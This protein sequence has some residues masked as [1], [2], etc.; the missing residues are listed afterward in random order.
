MAEKVN[1]Q[2]TIKPAEEAGKMVVA[3]YL[4]LSDRAEVKY[5]ITLTSEEFVLIAEKALASIR[6]ILEIGR[7]KPQKPETG[8]TK[9][10]KKLES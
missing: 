7:A 8:K 5:T 10:R 4:Q 9:G 1:W 2:A 3:G 6:N